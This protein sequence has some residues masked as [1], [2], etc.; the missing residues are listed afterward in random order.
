VLALCFFTSSH[1]HI[2]WGKN[3]KHVLMHEVLD[4]HIAMKIGVKFICSFQGAIGLYYYTLFSLIKNFNVFF[5]W[6]VSETCG[7]HGT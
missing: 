7:S 2:P 1:C 3:V 5:Q 4:H 6:K